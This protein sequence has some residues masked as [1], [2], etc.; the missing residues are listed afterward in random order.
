[1]ETEAGDRGRMLGHG[2]ALVQGAAEIVGGVA[3]TA[4]GGTVEVAT[5]GVAT[6]VAVPVAVAGVAVAGHGTFVGTRA[7]GLLKADMQGAS[8]G[9]GSKPPPRIMPGPVYKTG[10]EGRTA[11]Q[12]KGWKEVPGMRS[13]GQD[14]FTDGK[15][16]FTRDADGHIGGAW[17]ELNRRGDRV[18]TLDDNLNVIGK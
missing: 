11:A 13:H 7:A 18:A 8:G 4:I 9:G 5:I 12:A 3:A 2:I 10:K 15:R 6:P 1:M 16:Y 17:K 14:V